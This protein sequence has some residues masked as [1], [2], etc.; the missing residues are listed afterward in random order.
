M[1]FS[2]AKYISC[3]FYLLNILIAPSFLSLEAKH[4]TLRI[5]FTE[6]ILI[7]QRLHLCF[8][9]C[10][11]NI[12]LNTLLCWLNWPQY[13]SVQWFRIM[14]TIGILFERSKLTMI[15]QKINV[16]LWKLIDWLE[17]CFLGIIYDFKIFYVRYKV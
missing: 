1:L 9:E 3:L 7:K 15:L 10:F 12:H 4:K 2:P 14:E 8:W 11:Y 16:D 5:Y 13:Y 17:I 6:I